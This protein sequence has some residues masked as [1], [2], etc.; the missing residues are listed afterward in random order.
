MLGNPD[1]A[2][3]LA[4]AGRRLM[5]ERFTLR[6]T[7][8]AIDALFRDACREHGAALVDRLPPPHVAED[9]AA[10]PAWPTMG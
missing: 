8:A 7:V 3:E 4:R 6:R 5:L 10:E 2:G 9:D 1:R